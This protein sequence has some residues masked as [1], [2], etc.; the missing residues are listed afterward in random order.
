[1]VQQGPCPHMGHGSGM[2]E[3]Q[4]GQ[5]HSTRMQKAQTERGPKTPSSAGRSQLLTPGLWVPRRGQKCTNTDIAA[6]LSQ[7][8]SWLVFVGKFLELFVAEDGAV[9]AD[10]GMADVTASALAQPAFHL[11]F[12]SGDDLLRGKPHLVQG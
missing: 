4:A 12:E 10:I 9:F 3:S 8:E 7:A 6:G 11:H 1:M 2:M 5:Q